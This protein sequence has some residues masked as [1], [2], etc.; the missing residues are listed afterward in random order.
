MEV[1]ETYQA[2]V[3]DKPGEVSTRIVQVKTPTP[4]PGQIL[5]KLYG[6]FPSGHLVTLLTNPT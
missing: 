3:Y 5:V 1:P 2:V 4:G 6:I